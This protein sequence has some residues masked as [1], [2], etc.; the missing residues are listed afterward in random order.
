LAKQNSSSLQED[1]LI[2]TDPSVK[3]NAIQPAKKQFIEPEI[4]NA[5]DVLE[6]TTFFQAVTTG[7]T[8]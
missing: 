6:A 1:S 8:N 2:Q 5:V 4:S 7:A 3:P